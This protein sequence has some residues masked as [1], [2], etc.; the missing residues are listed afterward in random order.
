MLSHE[1][2]VLMAIVTQ[3]Q[4]DILPDNSRDEERQEVQSVWQVT[5]PRFSDRS[6]DLSFQF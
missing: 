3:T 5:F 4:T 1:G 6:V 2:V